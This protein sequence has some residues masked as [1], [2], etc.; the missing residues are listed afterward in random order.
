MNITQKGTST[1]RFCGYLSTALKLRRF[2]GYT[3]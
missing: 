1:I 2:L 3:T